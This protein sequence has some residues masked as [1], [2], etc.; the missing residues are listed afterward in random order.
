MCYAWFDPLRSHTPT[1]ISY[2]QRHKHIKCA[3][4]MCIEINNSHL[5]SFFAKPLSIN[6]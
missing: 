5:I 4:A 3:Y 2:T 1:H 6:E